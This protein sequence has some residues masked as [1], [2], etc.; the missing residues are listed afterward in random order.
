MNTALTAA[1]SAALGLATATYI[2]FKPPT[3]TLP[4][5]HVKVSLENNQGS[6]THIGNGYY[7]TAAHVVNNADKVTLK[8]SAGGSLQ[9]DIL[10]A[11]VEYD[12]ALM[13]ADI[14]TVSAVDLECRTPQVG[15]P[16]SYYGN[17]Q[18]LD[19]ITTWGRASGAAQSVGPLANV[20]PVNGAII[21][22]MSGGAVLDA[23]GDMVGVNVAVMVMHIGMGG[24]PTS[25]GYIVP[26]ETVCMLMGRQ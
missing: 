25:I 5:A 18:N 20:V 7:I 13:K 8:D 26:A 4:D 1:V 15:E 12:I 11:S 22:G 14:A 21:P 19:H 2:H 10:W 17:P 24:G 16:L 23:D 9:A 6:A 3:V